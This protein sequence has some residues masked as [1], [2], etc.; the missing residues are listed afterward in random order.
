MTCFEKQAR[1][2]RL[3]IELIRAGIE[4]ISNQKQYDFIFSI[5]VMEHLND[6]YHVLRNI[7]KLLKANSCYRFICPNYN[8][9]YEPHF[10]KVL[11]QRKKQ[12]FYLPER[13][14]DWIKTNGGDAKGLYKSLNFITLREIKKTAKRSGLQLTINPEATL[15]LLRRAMNDPIL[16]RRHRLFSCL[17]KVINSLKLVKLLT[18]LPLDLQPVMD[19]EVRSPQIG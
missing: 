5:N 4:E 13:R 8:F 2:E 10:A 14:I 16:R 6:P 3:N 9:P 17:I 18:F 12:S 11:L 19:V 1:I 7:P 15:N